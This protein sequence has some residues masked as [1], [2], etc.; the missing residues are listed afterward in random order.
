MFAC[1]YMEIYRTPIIIKNHLPNIRKFPMFH[2]NSSD[3]FVLG[4]ETPGG[5]LWCLA[6]GLWQQIPR[7][8]WVAG[9][10]PRGSGL[11]RHIWWMLDWTQIWEVWRPS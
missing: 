4:H 10:S 9:W 5:V 7:V 8:L 1:F 3:P 2:L 11:F 6:V